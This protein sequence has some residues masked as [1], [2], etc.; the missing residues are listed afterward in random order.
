VSGS[1][2]GLCE[3]FHQKNSISVVEGLVMVA[4]WMGYFSFLFCYF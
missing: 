3:L 2:S 4:G 1:K